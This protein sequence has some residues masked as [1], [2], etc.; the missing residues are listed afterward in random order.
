MAETLDLADQNFEDKEIEEITE[1]EEEEL[2]REENEQSNGTSAEPTNIL[3]VF[4]L[5]LD[6]D[7]E[8]L[9][10]TGLFFF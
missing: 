7:D 1:K 10:E 6:I 2:L 9:K 8:E 3:A 5:P 4:N